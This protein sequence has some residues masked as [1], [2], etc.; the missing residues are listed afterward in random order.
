MTETPTHLKQSLRRLGFATGVSA[1]LLWG[2]F[3]LYFHY[4][5]GKVS[6]QEIL[7]HRIIWSVPVVGL[8][9]WR[10]DRM[11]T[12]LPAI[13]D[14]RA[15]SMLAL[16]G[17]LIAVNWLVFVYGIAEERLIEVS[18][19]YFINPLVSV[20]LGMVFLRE[21]LTRLQYV[22]LALVVIGVTYLIVNTGRLPWISLVLAFSFGLYGLTRKTVSV[23]SATGF[24]METLILLP[25]ALAY[26]GYLTA[27][28]RSAFFSSFG[29]GGLLALGGPLTALPLIL[30]TT[31]VRLL[32]LSTMG[33][34]QYIAPTLQFALAVYAFG[35]PFDNVKATAFAFIWT[36]IAIFVFDL[37]RRRR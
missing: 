8:L 36:A 33:F 18:L 9:L 15:L 11:A 24:F 16:S 30:Y 32:P 10:R 19:G 21:R 5:N 1:Y 28:G 13:R 23:D 4:L 14:R 26:F 17:T 25:F 27:T 31:A 6:P 35:E 37:S 20:A 7:A 12:V 34:L 29:I 3:P 22:S 2:M